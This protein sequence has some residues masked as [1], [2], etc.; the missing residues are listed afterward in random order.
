MQA[1]IETSRMTLTRRSKVSIAIPP[2]GARSRPTAGRDRLRL[3]QN[4]G[5]RPG[6]ERAALEGAPLRLRFRRTAEGARID[7]AASCCVGEGVVE[8]VERV[9]AVDVE[10]EALV[11]SLV[12]DA[13][14]DHAVGLVPEQVDVDAVACTV[15]QLSF[16]GDHPCHRSSLLTRKGV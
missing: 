16:L 11:R 6:D 7:D 5:V 2:C 9:A 4:A 14:G 13:D 15:R 10:L 3:G 8:R 12:E 1:T